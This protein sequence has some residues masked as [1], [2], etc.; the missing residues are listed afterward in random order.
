M[1]KKSRTPGSAIPDGTVPV[2]GGREPC[3][4]GSGRRYKACHGRS[5]AQPPALVTRPFEGLPGECDW[6]ALREIV[7]AATAALRL[8]P[9]P[10]TAAPTPPSDH[11]EVVATEATERPI[12]AATV[13]PMAWPALTRANGEVLLGVQVPGPSADP[14]RDLAAALL[15]ALAAEPGT[16]VDATPELAGPDASGEPRLQDVLDLD[17]PFEVRVHEGF[18]FWL[19]GASDTSEEVKASLERA[20]SAVIPTARLTTV[21]AA[22]W[23]RMRQRNHLRWVMPHAEDQLLDAL[24]RLHAAGADSLGEGTRFV[25]SFR[26]QGLLVPVW[27]LHQEIHA[28]ALEEPAAAYAE[29]LGE[30]LGDTSPLTTD[31]RRARSGLQT[32]Q[33]TLR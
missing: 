18:D 33:I 15:A 14:S 1:G 24:A 30:A 26:A 13:L 11:A 2:V 27:D 12:T 7:P 19:E 6:V 10:P 32:R 16:P 20:N 29:R 5:A 31:Q 28:E 3:P 23:C 21:E 8:S 17:A 9:T 25:G 22:Y 4:C